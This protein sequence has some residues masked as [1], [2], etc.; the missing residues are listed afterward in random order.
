MS[1]NKTISSLPT[2]GMPRVHPLLDSRWLGWIDLARAQRG[3]R[4][5]QMLNSKTLW[6]CQTFWNSS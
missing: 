3:F 5:E 4:G 2:R 6:S 1:E